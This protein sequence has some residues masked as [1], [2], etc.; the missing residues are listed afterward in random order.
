MSMEVKLREFRE[1]DLEAIFR[2]DEA[3]F[4]ADFRFDRESMRQFVTRK[5]AIVVLAVATEGSGCEGEVAGFVIVHLE[6]RRRMVRGYV[7]TVD[8]AD[9][10]RRRGVGARLMDAAEMAVRK[11]GAAVMDLHVYTEND[12]A[13]KFYEGRGYVRAGMVKRFYGTAGLPAF[14]YRKVLE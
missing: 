2:L 7:V 9:G 5:G 1:G 12:G 11:S 3:C 8:T 13:I 10:W 4:A 6:G 14:T